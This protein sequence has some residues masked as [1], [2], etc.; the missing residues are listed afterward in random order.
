VN[1]IEGVTPVKWFNKNRN[2]IN[3]ALNPQTDPVPPID[4]FDYKTNLRK[5][6]IT[7]FGDNAH[8]YTFDPKHCYISYP[9]QVFFR[10]YNYYIDSDL[11]IRFLNEEQIGLLSRNFSDEKGPMPAIISK[12]KDLS[13]S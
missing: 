6:L 9:L 2:Y 1:D 10:I 8:Q 13:N 3:Y 7:Y 5:W 4:L 12:I 11:K